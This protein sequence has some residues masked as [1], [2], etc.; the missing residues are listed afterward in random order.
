MP[1]TPVS[2]S[3]DLWCLGSH[4][5]LCGDSTAA[6]DVSRLLDGVRPHLLISDPPYGVQYDPDWRNRAGASET[7]RTGRS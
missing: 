6:L 5:L 2:R 3:G 4:R 7:Q 1:A